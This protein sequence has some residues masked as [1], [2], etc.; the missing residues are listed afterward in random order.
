VMNSSHG[1]RSCATYAINAT[2]VYTQSDREA[3]KG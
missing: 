3:L 2:I 1:A